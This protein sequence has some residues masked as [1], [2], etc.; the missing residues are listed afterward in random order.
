M[1]SH[2]EPNQASM[3]VLPADSDAGPSGDA[4]AVGELGQ[5]GLGLDLA[6]ERIAAR[7]V[8]RAEAEPAQSRSPRLVKATPATVAIVPS[9]NS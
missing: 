8:F 7:F 4:V 2:L 6:M 5:A 1:K 3:D 9:R